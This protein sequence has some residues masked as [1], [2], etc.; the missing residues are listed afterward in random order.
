M[1]ITLYNHEVILANL[2]APKTGTVGE[3]IDYLL[4][5][6]KDDWTHIQVSKDTSE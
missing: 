5:Y 4:D 2:P 3:S 6:F 1:K